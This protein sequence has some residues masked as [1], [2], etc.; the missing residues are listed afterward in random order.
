MDLGC[1]QLEWCFS[2]AD[3]ICP[4]MEHFRSRWC[5][6]CDFHG[7]LVCNKMGK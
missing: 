3:D 5:G 4:L 1:Y 7:F 2:F 6:T